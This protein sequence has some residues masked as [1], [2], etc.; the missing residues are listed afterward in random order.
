MERLNF[1]TRVLGEKATDRLKRHQ[2]SQTTRSSSS[3]TV[4]AI[5]DHSLK[6][7][8]RVQVALD[9]EFIG[10]AKFA[11]MDNLR[12]EDL[13]LDDALRGGFDNRFEL[14]SALRRA[15]YRFKPLNEYTFYRCRFAWEDSHE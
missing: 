10:Y 8:E 14:F 11:S 4:M 9:D 1:T 3:S 12:L 15:G 13:T 5:S 7:G 2:V 6:S